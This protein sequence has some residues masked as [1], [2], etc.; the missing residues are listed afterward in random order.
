MISGAEENKTAQSP[1]LPPYSQQASRTESATFISIDTLT[2]SFLERAGV[3]ASQLAIAR[4]GVLQFSRAYATKPPSGFSPVDTHSLFRIASCSKMFTCAAVDALR[5]R[6]KLDMNL[7][8]F[9]F[10]GI[11]APAISKDEPDPLVSVYLSKNTF[12]ITAADNDSRADV[13]FIGQQVAAKLLPTV[14]PI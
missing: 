13:A 11:R 9:P 8:V 7:K 2:R 6:R 10:L 14:D 3:S 5:S 12:L 1:E 4:N